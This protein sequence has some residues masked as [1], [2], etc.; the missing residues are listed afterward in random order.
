MDFGEQPQRHQ[1]I[2]QQLLQTSVTSVSSVR[3]FPI[4]AF[5]RVSIRGQG[6]F[7]FDL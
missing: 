1:T 5:L 3:E 4:L 7:L 6:L 2:D